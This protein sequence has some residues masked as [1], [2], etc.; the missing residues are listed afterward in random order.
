MVLFFFFSSRRRHTRCGRDWS[1]DVCSSDLRLSEGSARDALS[2]LDQA[3][4]LGGAEIGEDVLEQ[5]LGSPRQ[6]V[7]YAIADAVAVGDTSGVFEQV[8][9]LVQ[10]GHDF[11]HVTSEC[12]Q[13]FRNLLL[14]NTAPG[15]ADLVDVTPNEYERVRTQTTKFTPADLSQTIDLLLTTQTNIQ[16]TT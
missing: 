15:Q 14:A 13:H 12:L 9:A 10:E 16:W 7:Q 6:D 2:L 4:V 5:L 3:T 8:H 1:S 11:R